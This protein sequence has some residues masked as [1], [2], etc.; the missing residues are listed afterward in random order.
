MK[1]QSQMHVLDKSRRRSGRVALCVLSV[2]AQPVISQNP[3]PCFD[4]I[5]SLNSVMQTELTRIRNGATP[6]NAYMYNLCNNT[7]FDATTS[8]LEPVLNNVMFVCGENG[9][10]LGRC[11]IL[12]GS[13][14]VQIDDSTVDTYPIQELSFMGITF[15]SFESNALRTGTSIGAYASSSTTATFMDC[16]WEEFKSDF[17]IRQNATGGAV[18]GSMT[19]EIKKSSITA[20]SSGV[21]VDN[22]AGLLRINEIVVSDVSAAAF[23]ATANNGASF[24]SGMTMTCKFYLCS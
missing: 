18:I 20:G 17:V 1:V 19:V 14:Q 15:S 23:L 7:F 16:T 9:N 5:G 6:Q 22:N 2:L 8:I 13:V 4:T 11:V 3:T 12:G 21:V 10:R 24:L